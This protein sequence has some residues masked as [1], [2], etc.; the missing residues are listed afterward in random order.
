[1]TNDISL[2]KGEETESSTRKRLIDENLTIMGWMKDLDWF[3][4][5]AVTG[6]SS[7]S[8]DGR[9]DYLLTD[10]NGMPLAIVE[11]KRTSVNVEAG[12][13]QAKEYADCI[14]EMFHV[15]PVIFL[16]NGYETHILTDSKAPERK[17]SGIFSRKDLKVIQNTIS[18]KR[19][20][21]NPDIDESIVNRR[22]QKDAIEAVCK[23][24]EE[25]R[26]SVLLEMATGS[27]KTRTAVALTKVL[28]KQNWVVNVLFLVDRDKLGR[29]AFAAFNENYSDL[30]CTNATDKGRFDKDARCVVCSYQTM[31]NLI[32]QTKGSRGEAV[33]SPGHFDLIIFDECHR[34]LYNVYH[35]IK[36]Y[37][38]GLVVGMTATPRDDIGRDTYAEFGCYDG[39]PT[40]SYDMARGVRGG[41]LV[42]YKSVIT[43][44]KILRDGIKYSELSDEGKQEY[45]MEFALPDG[46]IPEAIDSSKIDRT[47]FNRDTIA[48][49][50]A[51]LMTQGLTV[52]NGSMIGK[53]IIFARSHK[54]AEKIKRVF[55]EEYPSLSG[56]CQIID[57]HIKDSDTLLDEF[58]DEEKM[59]RIAISEDM[60]DTGVDVRSILNLV[61]LKPVFSKT[62]FLQMI[63]RGTRT[64]PGLMD[65][66]D[67]DIFYI[68]DFCDNFDFFDISPNGTEG[69]TTL[70]IQGRI[71]EARA[72]IIAE[73]N[74]GFR[75]EEIDGMREDIVE[76]CL[77]SVRAI[78]TKGFIGRNHLEYIERYSRNESYAV[79][80]DDGV[81]SMRGEL[82]PLI[83]PSGEHELTLQF[84]LEMYRCIL[85]ALKGDNASRY[86]ASIKMKADVLSRMG[87]IPEVQ[88]NMPVIERIREPEYLEGCGPVK[89]DEIRRMLRG[90]IPYIPK[91]ERRIIDTNFKDRIMNQEIRDSDSKLTGN[92]RYRE[93]MERYL[94]DNAQEPVIMKL[95]TN[96][97]LNS[98]DIA[99]LE[100]IM[101]ADVGTK[102]EYVEDC[103]EASL[104][105]LIRSIVGLDPQAVRK[106]FAKYLNDV[107]LNDEQ[108]YF[109]GVVVDYVVRNGTMMDMNVLK[110]SPFSD[111]GSFSDLFTEPV[112]DKII[113]AIQEINT[114]AA[115]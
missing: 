47:V 87:N 37:F 63:G 31:K 82:C 2:M 6:I 51:I 50:L 104:G 93:K 110:G 64:C 56:W 41:Y 42:D 109:V 55:D 53:T 102:E 106:V 103:G 26:R 43:K 113:G 23:A 33:F 54:H 40:Y 30:P 100:R 49:A 67:K 105:V 25:G 88:R 17:V 73:I 45:E 60:L 66:H 78:N 13:E 68:F 19:S 81:M 28:I 32:D 94:R 21:S 5:Y 95:R 97:P 76:D 69:K 72:A 85:C 108:E 8:G 7:P 38:D 86:H 34:S 12:R 89:L 4:E 48:N 75:G 57:T 98:D 83:L 29:Q 80:N 36:D 52:N 70:S 24:F 99:E 65:G 115:V 20:L 61:F 79:L 96:E 39:Y 35:E 59:P 91:E 11:A 84:D 58:E 107:V 27:G 18:K 44:L 62:K 71:F 9:V 101:W 14:E 46:T 10:E 112:W 1:M 15:R 77:Q 74:R 22:Y 90:L 92:I 114:N 111:K 3:E 16:T